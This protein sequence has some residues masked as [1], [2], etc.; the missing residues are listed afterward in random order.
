DRFALES[1]AEPSRSVR[2][3]LGARYGI[4]GLYDDYRALLDAGGGDALVVCSPAGTHA[5]VVLAALDAG[6]HVF[7][8]KPMCMTL[9]GAE[10]PRAAPTPLR[11]PT[12]RSCSP[13]LPPG[14]TCSWRSRCASRC[15]TRTRSWR[16]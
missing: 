5:E 13:R 9:R 14:S 12:P 1:L 6:V 10:W 7:V 2:E 4:G 16:R 3:A 11:P 8:E 15:A